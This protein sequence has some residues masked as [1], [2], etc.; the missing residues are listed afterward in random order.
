MKMWNASSGTF[1]IFIFLLCLLLLFYQT[2]DITTPKKYKI[3]FDLVIESRVA[4]HTNHV[5]NEYNSRKYEM[6]IFNKDL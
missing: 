1:I 5:D 3:E 6:C 4:V 2:F